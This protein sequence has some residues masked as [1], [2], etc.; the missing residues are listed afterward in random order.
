LNYQLSFYIT[1]YLKAGIKQEISQRK[2]QLP[3]LFEQTE[4]VCWYLCE[5]TAS[6]VNIVKTIYQPFNTL[7]HSAIWAYTFMA[8][9]ATTTTCTSSGKQP[10]Q[11]I[12][13]VPTFLPTPV[14]LTSTTIT[15]T[16]H[17]S[18]HATTTTMTQQPPPPSLSPPP[19]QQQ[20]Q[21]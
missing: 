19:Q 10:C 3:L 9:M 20:Q 6:V 12:S 7:N 14:P 15:T 13:A 5:P 8:I 1:S 17:A 2:Q 18:P 16:P 21:Q 4:K 11:P